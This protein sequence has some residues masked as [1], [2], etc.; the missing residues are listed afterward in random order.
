MKIFEE[1]RLSATF[2]Y[3]LS[4]APSTRRI[5]MFWF[6]TRLSATQ[7]QNTAVKASHKIVLLEL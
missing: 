2:D 6:V 7:F 1:L 5:Q 3:W 4:T